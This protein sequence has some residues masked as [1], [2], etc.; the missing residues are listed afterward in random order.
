MSIATYDGSEVLTD[1][2]TLAESPEEHVK[3]SR[4]RRR[5]QTTP[6]VEIVELSDEE[7]QR[8]I[9]EFLVEKRKRIA[10]GLEPPMDVNRPIQIPKRRSP[11]KGRPRTSF[12]KEV[13]MLRM[14]N[15][16]YKKAGRGRP[17]A[18]Q[19]RVKLKV[20]WDFNVQPDVAYRL[21]KSKAAVNKLE[22]VQA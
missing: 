11:S 7:R 15:G 12:E 17:G 3:R 9:E 1:G 13:T 5:K 16:C 14:Q 2:G 19:E 8:M 6:E 22:P 18:G 10:A 21:L 4:G 20:A